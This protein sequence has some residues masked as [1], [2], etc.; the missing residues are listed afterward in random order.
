MYGG[1]PPGFSN[2][3]VDKQLLYARG[4]V[5]DSGCSQGFNV[6]TLAC[7]LPFQLIIHRQLK[8]VR[9]FSKLSNQS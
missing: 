8:K 6:D 1:T 3:E 7:L 9:S 4:Y 2:C 5:T